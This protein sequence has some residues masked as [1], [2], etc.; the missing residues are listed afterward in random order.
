MKR[1]IEEI[2]AFVIGTCPELRNGVL[3]SGY[4]SRSEDDPVASDVDIA[5][6]A[7]PE[8][9]WLK[10]LNQTLSGWKI[11]CRKANRVIVTNSIQGREVNVF[12]T[13]D[14]RKYMNGILCRQ[15]ELMLAQK[16]KLVDQVQELKKGGLNTEQA[17]CKALHIESDSHSWM[18]DWSS[19]D[20]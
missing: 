8:L 7:D 11:S 5:L 14:H 6:F 9:D 2:Y 17:W 3:A 16:Y 12:I 19:S 13:L 4:P 10:L 1:S 18:I 15:H 20:L